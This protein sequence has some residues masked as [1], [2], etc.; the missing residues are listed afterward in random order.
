M[1]DFA[2][3]DAI[4]NLPVA[5]L[6]QAQMP[7]VIDGIVKPM[8]PGGYSDSG[9]DIAFALQRTGVFV[10]TPV[11]QPEAGHPLDWVFADTQQGIDQA[12]RLGAQVLWLNTILFRTHPIERFID[13]GGWVVGQRPANVERYDDKWYTNARLRELG[14]PIP[15]ARIVDATNQASLLDEIGTAFSFPI[16]AKPIRGRG[17]AGVVL[18]E[19]EYQL[20]NT[21]ADMLASLAYGDAIM[22]EEYLPGQ[23]LTLTVMPAGA[24]QIGGEKRTYNAPWSLPPVRRFNHQGGVAPYNGLVA[25]MANSEVVSEA[26]LATPSVRLLM[27]QCEQAAQAVDAL[28]PIRIDCRQNKAGHYYLFDLNMKP[29]MTGAGRPDRTDQDSLTALAARRIKWSYSDLLTN[30]LSH[31]WR[32]A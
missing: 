3:A 1:I 5:I 12:T 8:K 21:L 20:N 14:L 26:E 13:Q 28:A 31:A 17:S 18:V 19:S 29:N 11:D 23:E 15:K 30:M 7:P 16:I 6:Y 27:Q 2:T 32:Q 22:I 25:V 24:Y 10:V 4:R 9:A